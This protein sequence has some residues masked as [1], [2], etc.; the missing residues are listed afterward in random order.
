MRVEQCLL[1]ASSVPPTAEELIQY[2]LERLLLSREYP[3][4]ICPSEA[5]RA[6]SAQEVEAAGIS[7]WRD[8]M[9]KTREILW[10]MRDRGEVE[11]V[12]RGTLLP[13][14]TTLE[15]VKGPL[16]ARRRQPRLTI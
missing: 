14:V 11:I 6:L 7:H 3:K 8:L 15:E 10:G 13:D 9:P 16:R 5:P 1:M 4:T 12:Q 2:H